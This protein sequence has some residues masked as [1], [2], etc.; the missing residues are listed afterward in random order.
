MRATK[1]GMFFCISNQCRLG[2]FGGRFSPQQKYQRPILLGDRP[3]DGVREILPSLFLVAVRLALADRQ[4]V[5]DEEDALLGPSFQVSVVGFRMKV[6][7]TRIVHQFLVDISQGGRGLDS[8][9]DGKTEAVGLIRPVVGILP[10]ND[11]FCLG[12]GAQIQRGKGVLRG[13]K[14][15]VFVSVIG[16]S[17]RRKKEM[18]KFESIH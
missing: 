12:E 13:W 15:G 16:Y 8:P 4:N 6:L 9:A 18:H 2:L 5:V 3:N 1:N 10:D 17:N 14:D 11:Q 7:H